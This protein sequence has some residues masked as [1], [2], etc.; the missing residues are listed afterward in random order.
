MVVMSKERDCP[1]TD[2]SWW[3]RRGARL[4]G[5]AFCAFANG[6]TGRG[7]PPLTSFALRIS[8]CWWGT[9]AK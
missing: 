3:G 9:V 7:A 4:P 5:L 1:G 8:S 6:S 2:S